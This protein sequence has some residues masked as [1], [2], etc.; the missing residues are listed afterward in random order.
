[1]VDVHE[2]A[3][4]Q[5]RMARGQHIREITQEVQKL[6]KLAY[7]SM[8]VLTREH[9]AGK[10]LIQAVGDKDTVF[11]IREKNPT[12]IDEAGS[13]YER[14]QA[15]TSNDRSN[16]CRTSSM[17]GVKPQHEDEHDDQSA[18]HSGCENHYMAAALKRLSDQT[19]RRFQE[20]AGAINKLS[21]IYQSAC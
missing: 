17:R 2:Q 11:Y 18:N 12:T 7:P 21:T 10:Y 8:D 6:T 20:L 19:E 1:V 16:D 3:L 13:L 5:I 15:L 9:F 4:S 14:Y